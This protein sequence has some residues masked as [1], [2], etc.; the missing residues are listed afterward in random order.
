MRKDNPEHKTLFTIPT[1]KYSTALA[2]TKPLPPQRVITGHKQTDAYLWVLEVIQLNEPA[3]L[4]AAEDA[5]KKLKITPKQAQERYS[6]YLMKSGA[7]PFQIA[8]GTMSMDNPQGYINGAKRNIEKASQVRATFGSY[9]AALEDVEAERLIQSSIN[10]ISDH[11]WGWSQEE[12]EAK[13]IGGGRSTEIDRE[14]RGYVAGYQDVLP[15]PHTLSDIIREFE[16]WDW[17]YLMRDSAAHEEGWEYGYSGHHES[18]YDRED[19]LE[20]LMTTIKPVSRQ[21]ATDACRWVLNS[22]RLNDRGELTES[23]ILNLVGECG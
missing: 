6:A 4:Q 11:L 19:Y 23:I 21:E 16:Y 18:V 1:A 20:T 15:S 3:H 17:L 2:T 13:I 10:Y 8:F 9:A 14:R 22:E 5:L 12:R 7:Q